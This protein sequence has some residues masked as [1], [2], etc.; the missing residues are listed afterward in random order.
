MCARRWKRN[1]LLKAG[2]LCIESM[3]ECILCIFF[4]WIVG[5]I[6]GTEVSIG[7]SGGWQAWN[8]F[9]KG[10]TIISL[11]LIE[12][13]YWMGESN[14]R[15]SS[16]GKLWREQFFFY[17]A[18]GWEFNIW[19]EFSVHLSRNVY[20]M[21]RKFNLPYFLGFFFYYEFFTGF[22]KILLE[23]PP[24]IPYEVPLRTFSKIRPENLQASSVLVTEKALILLQKYN[25]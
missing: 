20:F 6:I 17:F 9:S 24:G 10:V 7:C 3:I 1:R 12:C 5:A 15:R 23:L 13:H 25:L 14:W 16:F 22:M 8:P 4:L 18:D 2:I 11:F 21:N 19:L